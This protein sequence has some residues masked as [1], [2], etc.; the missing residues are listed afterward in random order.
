MNILIPM[1]GLG[2]RFRGS[3]FTELKPMIDIYGK[4][5]IQRAV[6]SFKGDNESFQSLFV[7][8]RDENTEKIVSFC[9]II[10]L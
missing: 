2:S 6:E 1:A 5:M 8:R 10:L 3:R 7:L 4:P 9:A